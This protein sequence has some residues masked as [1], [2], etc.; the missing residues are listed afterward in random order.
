[1]TLEWLKTKVPPPIYAVI[2]AGIMWGLDHFAP[3]GQLFPEALQPLAWLFVVIGLSFDLTSLY[4]F[5]KRRTTPNPIKPANASSLVISGLY[6]YSR[7]P[8][9]VGLLLL[10]IAWGI[11]LGS[12]S[13]VL[14]IPVFIGVLTQMQIKPEERALAQKFGAD[15][16][17]YRHQV[18]RWI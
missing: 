16:Q 9:Y 3:I 13:A 5:V 6:R 2:A 14:I 18:R 8:M 7:N 10:L 17:R 4:L 15:Y 12:V 11:W 1:M